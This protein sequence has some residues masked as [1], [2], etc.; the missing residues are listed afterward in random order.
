MQTKMEELIDVMNTADWRRLKA[1]EYPRD[2]RN[3][4]AAEAL[5]RLA[6]EIVAL[7]GTEIHR[8]LEDLLI[9]DGIAFTI[10]ASNAL[11]VIGF[12][13]APES[14]VELAEAIAYALRPLNP[15]YERVH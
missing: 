14:G 12:T 2:S 10:I 13:A 8:E 15:N 1:E 4:E 5:E 6:P 7:N 3:I 11:R 9:C